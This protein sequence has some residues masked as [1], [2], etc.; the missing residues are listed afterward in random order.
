MCA[1]LTC[2]NAGWRSA[3]LQGRSWRRRRRLQCLPEESQ[4]SYVTERREFAR[5]PTYVLLL[6]LTFGRK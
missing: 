5:L 1:C 2:W 3:V 6:K 4:L